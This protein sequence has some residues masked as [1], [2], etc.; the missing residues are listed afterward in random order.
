[1]AVA[2]HDLALAIAD[3]RQTCGAESLYDD[4]LIVARVGKKRAGRLLDGRTWDE[5]P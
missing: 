3:P 5:M 2:A 1:V 4:D